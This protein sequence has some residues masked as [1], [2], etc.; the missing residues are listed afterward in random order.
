VGFLAAGVTR[1]GEEAAPTY[2]Q[3]V[4]PVLRRNCTVCHSVRNLREPEV[5]GGLALDSYE[6]ILKGAKNMIVHVGQ[7]A[8]SP[9]VERI[10]TADTEKRMPLGALPLSPQSIALLRRWIDGGAQEGRKPAADP[11]V[12]AATTSHKIRKLDIILPTNALLPRELA[13]KAKMGKLELVLKVGPLSPVTGVAF[14]PDGTLLAAACYGRV[15]VW[16]LAAARPAKVLTNVLGAVHDVRF[17]PDGKILAV[18][19]GQPSAKGDLRLYRVVDWKLLAVLGGHQDVVFAIAFHPDGRHLA[20]ASFDRTVRLWD[21]DSLKMERILTQHSDFVYALAFGPGGQWLA[22]ASKDRSV[23]VVEPTTGK[24]RFT[25]G[26]M[27]Q[28]VLA[29]AVSPDGKAVVSSGFDSSLYWWNP[30]T[31]ERIRQQGGHGIGVHEITFSNDGKLVASAGA[32]RTIRL[33]DG[34]S[35]AALRSLNTASVNYAVAFRPDGKVLAS[36]S[37]D[38]LVRLWDVASGRQLAL[39]LALPPENERGDWLGLT[40]EGYAVGCS[41]LEARGRWQ[42][43]GQ[44]V[45]AAAIWKALRRPE[46][47]AK[48]LRGEVVPVASWK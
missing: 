48:A 20:S 22:S 27:E 1:A 23:K 18:A 43:N 9:L 30:Q 42:S 25:F 40:P 11:G 19:G 10:V 46:A 33:W 47:L 32:D 29:V 3:D 14:S 44:A 5:S 24:S 21:L 36:G 4:R 41:K 8:A 7:S 45:D 6:A 15:T 13:G 39:L 2:W 31:G 38:G 16:D 17:S 37:F 35:G 26:G 34:T 28:D 12:V